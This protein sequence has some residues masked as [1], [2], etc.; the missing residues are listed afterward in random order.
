MVNNKHFCILYL[1]SSILIKLRKETKRKERKGKEKR[2]K[3]KEKREKRKE[4]RNVRK[5][6][7]RRIYLILL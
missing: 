4:K 7:K 3:R 2:K 6:K 1:V 5:E